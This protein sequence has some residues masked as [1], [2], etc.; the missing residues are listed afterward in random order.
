[1]RKLECERKAVEQSL[2]GGG[3]FSMEN[4]RL[5]FLELEEWRVEGGD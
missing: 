5:G 4:R 2:A 3:G 1:M